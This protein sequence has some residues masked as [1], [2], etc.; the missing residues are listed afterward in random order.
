MKP[1]QRSLVPV[2]LI[3]FG[4]VLIIGSLVWFFVASGPLAQ[5][6]TAS[7]VQDIPYPE[8]ARIGIKDA[9]AAFE[10]GNSVFIDTRGERLYAEGHIPGAIVFTGE[11][12]LS[13]LDQ[14]DRSAWIITYCT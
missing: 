4:A 13:S 10:L 1:G 8:I 2:L 11:E 12:P 7:E 5:P 6:T 14:I 9:K 3:A